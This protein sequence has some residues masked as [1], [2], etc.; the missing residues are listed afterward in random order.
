MDSKILIGLAL[1]LGILA[2]AIIAPQLDKP[3]I[4]MVES[5]IRG[6]LIGGG[7]FVLER[8]GQAM[9]EEDYTIFYHD[10]DGY[11]LLSQGVLYAEGAEISLAQQ[12]QFDRAFL[13]TFYQLAADTPAGSQIISAQMGLTGLTMEVRFGLAR[14]QAEV[15]DVANLALLDN[16]VIGH[17]AILLM[18]IRAEAI[19]RD[20]AAAIPQALLSLPASVKGPNTIEFAS[21]GATHEGKRF[22]V[23][24]GDTRIVLIEFEGRM[25]GLINETQGTFGYDKGRFPGGIELVGEEEEAFLPEGVTEWPITFAGGDLTLAGTLTLPAGDGPFPAALF[26]HGSGPVDRDGNAPGLAMDAYRQ[27]AR[28]LAA[29]GGIASLRFDKRGVGESEGD[30]ALASM[31]D[32]L[33]DLRA[34]LAALRSRSEIDASRVILIGH[35]EGAYLAPILAGEDRTLAGVALLA[36]AARPLDEITRWQVEAILRLQG[37]TEEQIAV[38]LEQEDEYIAFVE[39]S[40]GEWA[41]HTIEQLK[42]AMPWLTAEAA[43]RLAATPLALSWLREHYVA[44]TQAALRRVTVPVFALNGEKDLQVPP[45]EGERIREILEVAG[46]ED[47]TVHLLPNLNHL[48]RSHPEAP[49]LVYRHLE[50]PVDPR[51]VDLLR[52]WAVERLAAG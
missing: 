20:F 29:E 9:L 22:D 17:Y 47:V 33:D 13:P 31:S 48:L 15:T 30:A 43:A 27:L 7:S 12:A 3:D 50:D 14:Q 32:L 42:E 26:I 10:T 40:T 35:S 52:R 1:V 38:S 18:A 11:M 2:I 49:N 39:G 8:D 46:N 25:V 5:G 37:A 23:H 24:L 44:D 51:V 41:D 34:A 21:A 16:N 19:D 28:A 36:G 4:E 6:E 45:G